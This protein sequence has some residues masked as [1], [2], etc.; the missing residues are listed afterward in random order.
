MADRYI[1]TGATGFL[2]SAL[3]AALRAAGHEVTAVSRKAGNGFISWDSLPEAVS[4]AYCVINLAGDP[5]SKLPWDKNKKE[6]ILQS[7]LRATKSV[8]SALEKCDVKPKVLIQAS[9]AGFYGN[10][11]EAPIDETAHNGKGF[12]SD[13]CEQWEEASAAADQT[14]V[15][16]CVIRTATVLG[17]GGFLKAIEPMFKYGLGA[18][19][20]SGRQMMSFIH[21][22]DWVNAV[23]FIAQ[24]A[25]RGIYNLSSPKAVDNKHFTAAFAHTL[26]RTHFLSAPAFALKILL[27]SAADELLLVSQNIQPKALLEMGF[28]FRHAEINEALTAIYHPGVRLI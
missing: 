3:C 16:R 13:V 1:V 6:A 2:G 14:G 18:K 21:I 11:G 28:K 19:L 9:A 10:S 25:K 23:L 7:R 24:N 27:G 20:G 22:D 5:I 26:H 4:G 17:N 8:M 15:T 12:L